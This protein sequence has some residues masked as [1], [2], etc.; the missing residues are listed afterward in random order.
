M[1]GVSKFL[2]ANNS[3]I[4]LGAIGAGIVSSAIDG[5][6]DDVLSSSGKGMRSGAVAAG[7]T[8]GAQALFKTD[9]VQDLVRGE[10]SA[11]SKSVRG[12]Q[13]A[14]RRLISI[15]VKLPGAAKVGMIA[16]GAATVMDLGGRVKDHYESESL[17]KE[18]EWE[19]KQRVKEQKKKQKKQSY[20]YI[21]DGE[22]VLEMF[23]AR[24]G[25]HKMGNAR[26]N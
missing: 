20:G 15:G 13:E 19:M 17:K 9:T 1:K 18:Q 2:K 12:K 6:D 8:Y 23:N 5:D 21:R 11:I 10:I 24:S 26:F 3:K 22:I 25:H 14:E 4:I 16:I 7:I